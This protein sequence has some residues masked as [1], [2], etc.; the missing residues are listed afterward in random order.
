MAQDT[1]G[2]EIEFKL[3]QNET[4]IS[5]EGVKIYVSAIL[6]IQPIRLQATQNAIFSTVRS[7]YTYT[8]IR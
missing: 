7:P 3:L 2:K 4:I 8:D 5:Q 6:A 1:S